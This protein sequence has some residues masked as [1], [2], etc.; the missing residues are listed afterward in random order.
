MTQKLWL[1]RRQSGPRAKC[2]HVEKGLLA[3]HAVSARVKA[4]RRAMGWHCPQL[5][6][7]SLVS[8]F[9]FLEKEGPSFSA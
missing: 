1:F 4:G 7:R 5:F 6:R 9:P 8:W 3:L 2:S